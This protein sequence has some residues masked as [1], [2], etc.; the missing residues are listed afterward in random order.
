[1]INWNE[2][3]S[4]LSNGVAITADKD[5][6]NLA[7]PGYLEI[8]K[9]WEK[10]KFNMSSI[11]WINYYPVTHYPVS[12]DDTI[13]EHLGI[14][15]LRSWISQI[16]PGYC[17]PWHWDVD[18][19]EAKYLERG[20]LVRY[21]VFIDK[22]HAGHCFQVG[23]KYFVNQSQGTCIKWDNYKDWHAGSNAGLSPNYMFHIIG[24]C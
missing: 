19:N 24:T 7:T 17:A 9:M 6:W 3:I 18:D 1:V 23:D 2:V 5:K 15:K 13:C 14:N 4:K 11:K 8:Y 12:I 22:P 16:D 20:E 10:S 21:T